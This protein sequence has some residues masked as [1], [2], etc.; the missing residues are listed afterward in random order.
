MDS[1]FVCLVGFAESLYVS[2]SSECPLSKVPRQAHRFSAK[3]TFAVEN[4][5]N[6]YMFFTLHAITK[7]EEKGKEKKGKKFYQCMVFLWFYKC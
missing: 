3:T 1:I 4:P 6:K 2:V 7:K 5:P